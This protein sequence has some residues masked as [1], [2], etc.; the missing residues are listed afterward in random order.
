MNKVTVGFHFV[1]GNLLQLVA[2][3]DED[4]Q[5]KFNIFLKKWTLSKAKRE[6]ERFMTFLL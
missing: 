4:F 3:E 5:S 2:D 1:I 6:Q